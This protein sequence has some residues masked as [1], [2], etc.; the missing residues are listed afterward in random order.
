MRRSSSSSSSNRNFKIDKGRVT[1]RIEGMWEAELTYGG[2]ND[3]KEANWY[4]LNLKFLFRVKDTRG[5]K[6]FFFP[7]Y[8][9]AF[10]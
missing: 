7:L 3:D 10:S 4:L 8:L 6:L 1:F 2:D 9:P 5:S